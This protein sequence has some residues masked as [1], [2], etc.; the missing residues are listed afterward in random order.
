M[1]EEES[2][3]RAAPQEMPTSGAMWVIWVVTWILHLALWVLFANQFSVHELAFGAVAA[4]I[5][6]I[7]YAAVW[8]HGHV[9]FA[10]RWI[11]ALQIW[12]LPAYAVT[13][14]WE[15]LHGLLQ[16]LTRKE[17]A[18][19]V[20]SAAPFVWGDDSSQEVARRALAIIYTTLT[21]NFVVL[22]V[23][24]PKQ[25]EMHGTMLYHQILPGRIITIARNLGARE[26]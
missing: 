4:G 19:S 24:P 14:T 5:A 17:G 10:P 1:P 22:D 20:T 7:G 26:Q 11:D 8:K 3:H 13:G 15:V 2:G 6:V 21:P 18:P 25:G 9:P 12:R 23:L 16:Q